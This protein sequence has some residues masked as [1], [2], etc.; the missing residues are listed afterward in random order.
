M[1]AIL[2]VLGLIVGLLIDG[3]FSLPAIVGAPVLA[4]CCVLGGLLGAVVEA[5]HNQNRGE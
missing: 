5:L 2:A 1:I 4:I 3:L